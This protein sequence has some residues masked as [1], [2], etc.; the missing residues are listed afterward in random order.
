ML[1]FSAKNSWNSK[2]L[3]S[4]EEAI[5]VVLIWYSCFG[6]MNNW[7]HNINDHGVGMDQN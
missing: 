5:P 2:F 6:T 4:M 7:T 1:G 3:E